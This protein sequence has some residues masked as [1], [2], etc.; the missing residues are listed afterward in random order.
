MKKLKK[1]I[2]VKDSLILLIL[3]I[4]GIWMVVVT[5]NEYAQ[6]YIKTQDE[7]HLYLAESASRNVEMLLNMHESG[8]KSFEAHS[9]NAVR[10]WQETGNTEELEE[11]LQRSIMYKDEVTES[12]LCLKD[13]EIIVSTNGNKEY[14]IKFIINLINRKKR[15]K[16]VYWLIFLEYRIK[17][18][19]IRIT[20]I[21]KCKFYN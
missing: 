15:I 21:C 3:V 7:H 6:E 9:I 16:W 5:F 13:R 1:N 4:V 8:M 17:I 19:F 20:I 10:T 2:R 14:K 12:I 18:Y 11:M